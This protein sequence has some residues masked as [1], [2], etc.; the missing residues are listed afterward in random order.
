V[1]NA[2][3]RSMAWFKYS[4]NSE[5]CS[6]FSSGPNNKTLPSQLSPYGKMK[7]RYTCAPFGVSLAQRTLH[8]LSRTG[9][10]CNAPEKERGHQKL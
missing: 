10:R 8:R 1:R 6:S 7:L 2:M 5:H 9:T 3:N 4:S